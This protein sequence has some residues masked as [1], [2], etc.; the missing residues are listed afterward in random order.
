[1]HRVAKLATQ[2]LTT[3]RVAR[4][5]DKCLSV[6][7][8]GHVYDGHGPLGF[9]AWL[10]NAER[11]AAMRSLYFLAAYGDHFVEGKFLAYCQAIEG[12]HIPSTCPE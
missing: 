2:Q 7:C 9:G 12:F 5:W 6:L 1:M 3:V 4:P 11:T 10:A 8:A